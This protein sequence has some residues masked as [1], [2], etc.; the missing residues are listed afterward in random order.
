M[1]NKNKLKKKIDLLIISLEALD[2]YYDTNSATKVN[3]TDQNKCITYYFSL[4]SL[5]TNKH[6]AHFNNSNYKNF[7]E[8]IKSIYTI[9]LIS[10][11][12]I[13]YH[14]IKDIINYYKYG[15]YKQAEQYLRR[16]KYIYF[17]RQEQY[18]SYKSLNNMSYINIYEVAII[19]LY[20][21]S[22]LQYKTGLYF[23]VKYLYL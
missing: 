11:Q 4:K 20:I 2:I 3:H 7:Q 9:Y 23:L 17:K 12:T 8:I 16:F 18:E 6:F 21:I 19:N 13:I 1:N 14:V 5:T 22:Q 10:Q 15:N